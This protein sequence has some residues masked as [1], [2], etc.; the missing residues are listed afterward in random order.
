MGLGNCLMA[1]PQSGHFVAQVI[2]CKGSQGALLPLEDK[3][4]LFKD[5]EDLL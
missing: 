3:A 5:G 2:H 4:T 1:A